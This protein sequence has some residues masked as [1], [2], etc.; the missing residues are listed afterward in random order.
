MV[1]L[2]PAHLFGAVLSLVTPWS[3][4]SCVSTAS[5]NSTN[6]LLQASSD[7]IAFDS[8]FGDHVAIWHSLH[9]S[10]QHHLAYMRLIRR[11][12]WLGGQ[13]GGQHSHQK[14]ELMLQIAAGGLVE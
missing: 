9:S 4:L 11:A 12:A 14:T 2:D 5:R 8:M 6:I 1:S 3:L 7:V 10:P 13:F